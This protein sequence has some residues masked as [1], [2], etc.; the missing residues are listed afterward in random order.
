MLCLLPEWTQYMV[1]P[2][3]TQEELK[4]GFCK[5]RQAVKPDEPRDQELADRGGDR[6]GFA[7]RARGLRTGQER[8]P[9]G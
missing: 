9:A 7:D 2:T 5:T 4:D 8:V 1:K 6:G 3:D